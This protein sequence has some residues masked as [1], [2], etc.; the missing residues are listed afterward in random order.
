MP[1][2]RP[3]QKWNGQPSIWD[4]GTT[5]FCNAKYSQQP[6]VGIQPTQFGHSP[7]AIWANWWGWI[8]AKYANGGRRHRKWLANEWDGNFCFANYFFSKADWTKRQTR[9]SLRHSKSHHQ[10][11]PQQPHSPYSID[12]MATFGRRSGA[13]LAQM[14]L[15]Q[16]LPDA[17]TLLAEFQVNRIHRFQP[18]TPSSL[19]KYPS[20]NWE[21]VF[22]PKLSEN[23]VWN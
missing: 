14:M 6:L 17:G 16:S 3:G 10:Q 5:A 4:V 12:S 2:G 13:E 8:K 22:P 23:G 1:D 18:K 9:F 11:F 15:E 21:N 7:A 19:G 20:S